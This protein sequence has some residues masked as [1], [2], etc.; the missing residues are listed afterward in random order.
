MFL[1]IRISLSS[2]HVLGSRDIGEGVELEHHMIDKAVS[3]ER[4]PP[5]DMPFGKMSTFTS[6][7]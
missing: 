6:P 2:L 4:C 5:L 7:S 1:T 3:D